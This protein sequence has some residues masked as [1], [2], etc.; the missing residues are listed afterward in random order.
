MKSKDLKI[1]KIW[2]ISDLIEDLETVCLSKCKKSFTQ[3]FQLDRLRYMNTQ[4]A[5]LTYQNQ[6]VDTKTLRVR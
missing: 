5:F 3:N 2:E 1:A 6:L 4:L